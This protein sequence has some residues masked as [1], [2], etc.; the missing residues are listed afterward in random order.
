M[1]GGPNKQGQSPPMLTAH[2]QDQ[3]C[4]VCSSLQIF[5]IYIVYSLLFLYS[6]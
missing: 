6:F 3:V 5:F 1:N 4:L 2:I